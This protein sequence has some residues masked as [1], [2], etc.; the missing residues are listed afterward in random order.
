MRVHDDLIDVPIADVGPDARIEV[1]LESVRRGR[2]V[3]AAHVFDGLVAVDQQ[4]PAR[5]VRRFVLRMRHDF[6]ANRGRNYHHRV[7]SID[8]STSSAFKKSALRYFH[9]ASASTQTTT[10]SSSSA[11]S[12]RAT[13]TTAPA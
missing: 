5:F 4:Q 13:C 11:A 7:L 2:L 1:E 10:P 12:V 8:V 6:G 9:P 3:R